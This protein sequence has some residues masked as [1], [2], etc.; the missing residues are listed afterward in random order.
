MK[1]NELKELCE[2]A[3]RS[4]F[5]H[6]LSDEEKCGLQ[7]HGLT[8]SDDGKPLIFLSFREGHE[9]AEQF[10]WYWNGRSI[11]GVEIRA[12]VRPVARLC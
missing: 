1:F 12:E 7:G 3:M 6:Y 11:L 4:L 2:P 10:A 5:V 9:K 8:V